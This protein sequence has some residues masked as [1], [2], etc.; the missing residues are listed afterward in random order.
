[1]LTKQ[2]AGDT[3]ANKLCYWISDTCVKYMH[4]YVDP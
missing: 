4:Q 2:G 3:V 1:M